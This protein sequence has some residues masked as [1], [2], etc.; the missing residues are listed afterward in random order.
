MVAVMLRAILFLSTLITL[1]LSAASAPPLVIYAYDSFCAKGGL[2]PL[3]QEK[4]GQP[5]KCVSFGSAGE[6]LNQVALDGNKVRADVIVG[7]DATM[8]ARARKLDRFTTSGA[9]LPETIAK[10]LYFDREKVFVPFDY[11]YL[12]FVY[13][14]ARTDLP[15]K[16]S[17]KEF[18]TYTKLQKRVVIEDPRTSSLG[19]GLLVWSHVQFSG[20][21]FNEFWRAM[22]NQLITISPGWSGAY[23]LFSKGGADAVLSYTTSPAY[24]I[25]H[26]KRNTVKTISHPEGHLRQIES[27]AML[28]GAPQPAVAKRFI[29]FLLSDAIQSELPKRQWMYPANGT[30]KLPD[31]FKQ[32]APVPH[33]LDVNPTLVESSKAEWIREWTQTFRPGR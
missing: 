7:V 1:S 21:L 9:K 27:V 14:S 30:A 2:G 15:E 25:E 18:A 32:L 8:L 33:A 3:L 31:S 10:E 19:L 6:A 12:A 16:M 20:T 11:G 29:E 22:Q 23:G 26:E 5:V 4:F 28:R 17:L 24:H 13:D